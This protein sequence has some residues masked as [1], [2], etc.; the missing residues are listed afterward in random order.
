MLQKEGGALNYLLIFILIVK[1]LWLIFTFSHI[2]LTSYGSNT[3]IKYKKI[4][5]DI[6]EL[7]RV[8]FLLLIGLLLVYLYNHLT[9]SKVCIEGHTKIY[10][11]TFGILTILGSLQKLFRKYYLDVKL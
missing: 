4:V 3:S 1:I 5:D 9:P 7:L 10:L 11:Y 2:I 6:D 8:I